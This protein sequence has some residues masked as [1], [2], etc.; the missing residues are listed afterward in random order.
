MERPNKSRS[1]LIPTVTSI[2]IGAMGLAPATGSFGY[3]AAS[4]SAALTVTIETPAGG[5]AELTYRAG[6]GWTLEQRASVAALGF[7][8]VSSPRPKEID[9]PMTVFIDGPTGYTYVW[10]PGEGW[11]FI[12]SVSER[13]D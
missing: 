7:A 1:F 9:R 2:L 8:R 11:K 5:T 3:D 12:G 4:K 6:E 10:M 13:N